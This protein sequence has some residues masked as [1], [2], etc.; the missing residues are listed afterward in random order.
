MYCSIEEAWG[1]NFS[2]SSGSKEIEENLYNQVIRSYKYNF[3]SN[4]KSREICIV[5][6]Y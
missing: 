5:I 1:S 6:K 2:N 3:I 4:V